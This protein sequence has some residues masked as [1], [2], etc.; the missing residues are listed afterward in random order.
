MP[1]PLTL[2]DFADLGVDTLKGVGPVKLKALADLEIT[3]L[4]DLLTHYPRRHLDRTRQSTIG[5]LEEGDEATLLVTVD[6]VNL[7]R[8]GGRRTILEVRVSDGTGSVSVPFF[9]Q[10]WR[11][12]QLRPGLEIILFGRLETFRGKRQVTNAFIDFAG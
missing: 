7:R 6:R 5:D 11:E 10:P 8:L 2:A 4:L 1:E 12:K 9:N 3:S